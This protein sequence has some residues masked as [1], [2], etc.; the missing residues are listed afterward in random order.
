MTSKFTHAVALA[1]ADFA[2]VEG[3]VVFKAKD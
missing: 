1:A 2:T 3:T